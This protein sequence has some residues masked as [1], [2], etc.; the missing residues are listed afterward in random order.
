[1]SQTQIKLPEVKQWLSKDANALIEPLQAKARSLL[2]EVK[3]RVDDVT[4]S[5][6]KILHNSQTEMDK[7]N[8]KT[9]RFARNANKFAEGLINTLGALKV[10]D[11]TPY[12][13]IRVLC[14][15]LEKTCANVDQLRRS[16]YPYISPYF[17]FDRRRLDVFIKRLYDISKEMRSFLTSKYAVVKTVDDAYSNVDKLIQTLDQTKKNDEDLRQTEN[18]MLALEKEITE[19]KEKL[20]LVRSKK[21]FHELNMLDQRVDELRT[22]VKHN[23][24][25]LQKPFYK[26]Q[27]LS[28][29]G[30]V[31]VP[32]DELRKLEEYL[33]D[34]LMALAAADNGYPTLKSI[35]KKLETTMAQ[36]KLKLKATRLRKA[37]DQTDAVLNKSSLDQ[38]QK[39]GREA[40]TQRGQLMSSETTRALQSELTQLQEQL[41]TLQKEYDVTV[42]RNKTLRSDQTKLKERTEHLRKELEGQVSQVSRKN[43]QIV[44][45]T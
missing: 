27:S 6:Q 31:A 35:L 45:T 11:S 40:L 22:E 39:N 29:S 36:G 15:D 7:S 20:L 44:L 14:D 24:R 19:T 25:Y 43:V 23:L 1:M 16:A 28:R 3:E 5:S 8:P 9:H 18:R 42:A 41:E 4:E 38:L 10:S 37:Q 34:P 30:E 32:P 33:Q 26:L 21:E 12:E 17:I 13:S 2:R